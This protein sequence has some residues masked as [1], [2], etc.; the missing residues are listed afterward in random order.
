MRN[1]L[2]YFFSFLLLLAA[3]IWLNNTSL[4]SRRLDEGPTLLAHRG[5]G[6][7]FTREDLDAQTCTAS[8]IYPPEHEFIE[9]TLP[10][11]QAAFAAGAN[12]VE[13]DVHPT[14]DGHFAVFHDWTLDCRTDGKG[15]TREH[16]LAELKALDIGYG[17]T[18]DGG[19][20]F[21]FRGKGIG[22]MPSLDEVLAAFPDKRFLVHIKSNDASEGDK[23]A[24]FLSHLSSDARGRLMIYGAAP[25]IEA[26][27][28]KLPDIR[29][30][31]K[32]SL[33]ACAFDYI[34]L[35]W[36][37]QVPAACRSGL[38]LV[39]SNIAP[40]LW[41]WP[42]R[43]LQRMHEAGVEVFILGPHDGG[44]FSTGIDELQQLEDLP[45]GFSG[46]IWTNRIDR[47]GPAV[48]K[49]AAVANGR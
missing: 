5:L 7:T 40:W 47:I 13:F 30:G 6:Q 3:F 11:M 18:A 12:I 38:M 2:R 29:Y 1:M 8:R 15:V 31:S 49:R 42:N 27:H 41:G 35:G 23:L 46:G 36:L 45:S 16:T 22:L 43:F 19:K 37:G 32:T 17:Y 44:Q 34:K 20:T 9:N 4:L 25:P 33:K 14:T 26:V 48:P 39:P 10:S 24:A 28:A 21:P